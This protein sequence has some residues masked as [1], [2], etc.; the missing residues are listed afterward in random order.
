[1]EN[2]KYFP[3]TY[4][5]RGIGQI[6]LQNNVWTGLIFLAGICYDSLVMGFAAVL[7]V[8]V[9]TLTAILL[10]YDREAIAS[11]MYGFSATL[12]GVAL[13]FYFRPVPIIWAAVI[14]G[15]GLATIL[16][17]GFLKRNIPAFTFPFIVV[18]WCALYIF[19]HGHVVPDA[20][21]IAGSVLPDDDFTLSSHGFGE[22]IF[23]GS[24][25]AGVLF[26]IAVFIS[27]PV[28]ALYGIAASLLG[29]FISLQF[30]E[31]AQDI[32]MGLFSFNAVLC[33]ITFAG[34]RPR[35]GILVLTAVVLSVLI[36]VWLLTLHITVLTFPF[37][38]ASWITLGLKRL[39]PRKLF[40][41]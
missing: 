13:T 30:A 35:D 24:V 38:L 21:G 19:H 20:A 5:L 8:T 9:G 36:D 18:T 4:G 41:I 33:A 6:M 40:E 1:M 37:V 16:Q 11:G 3:L 12:T 17:H 29:A 31:P 27:S 25:V 32:H 26:F 2:K 10:R 39:L 15:A 14:V 28:A 7:S 23:Q 22:V 34:P